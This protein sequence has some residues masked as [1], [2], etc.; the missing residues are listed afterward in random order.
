VQ[1]EVPMSSMQLDM[2]LDE[3][4]KQLGGAMRMAREAGFEV[5]ED[6]IAR[7]SFDDMVSEMYDDMLADYGLTASDAPTRVRA[8]EV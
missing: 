4:I 7:L 6:A 1:L 2:R 5:G 3:V 8:C